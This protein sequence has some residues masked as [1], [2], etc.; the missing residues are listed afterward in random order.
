M[1]ISAAEVFCTRHRAL[2]VRAVADRYQRASEPPT[3]AAELR[4]RGL[5]V[6]PNLHVLTILPSVM[7]GDRRIVVPGEEVAN[8][9]APAHVQV[10]V[11]EAW[12][13][14]P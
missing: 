4:G 1:A 8:H 5:Q 6:N 13:A 7:K 11:P 10:S 12:E 3:L 9:V 2:R 14:F